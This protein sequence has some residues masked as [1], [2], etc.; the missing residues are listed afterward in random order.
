MSYNVTKC[1]FL[2]IFFGGRGR[3]GACYVESLLETHN[4]KSYII[5]QF[6]AEVQSH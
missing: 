3:N 4:R 1:T 5:S 2:A 6:C